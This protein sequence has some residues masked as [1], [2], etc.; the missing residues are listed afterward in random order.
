[1]M[2]PEVAPRVRSSLSE[3]RNP[4]PFSIAVQLRTILFSVPLMRCSGKDI[5]D[6]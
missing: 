6:N 5:S 2:G 4:L 3:P 1:M